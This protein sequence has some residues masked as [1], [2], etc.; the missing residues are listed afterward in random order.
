[1]EAQFLLDDYVKPK[2]EKDIKMIIKSD[3]KTGDISSPHEI[4]KLDFA[5]KHEC[6]S[7][8]RLRKS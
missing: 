3:Y 5:S 4:K 1:M 2:K 6:P 7:R 8:A